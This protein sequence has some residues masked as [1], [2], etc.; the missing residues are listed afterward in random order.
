MDDTPKQEAET[1]NILWNKTQL[2]RIKEIDDGRNS[3]WI[4]EQ[5]GEPI[6]LLTEPRWEDMFWYSY[7]LIP[8][9]QDE[10][11][12]SQLNSETFWHQW[13]GC[14]WRN[15]EFGVVA[16]G[17]FSGG[18][19]LPETGRVSMRALYIPVDKPPHPSQKSVLWKLLSWMKSL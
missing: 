5:W 18:F 17:P 9:T 19:E 14:T 16:T 13:E 4:M 2:A 3:D 10:K 11:V 8:L 6:A 12:L 1:S 15:C 7:R